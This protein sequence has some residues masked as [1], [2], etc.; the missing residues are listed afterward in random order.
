[1][2]VNLR[3]THLSMA[4]L[5]GIGV[6]PLIATAGAKGATY[7]PPTLNGANTVFVNTYNEAFKQAKIQQIRQMLKWDEKQQ[8]FARMQVLDRRALS[9]NPKVVLA[10]ELLEI[11]QH[12]LIGT[13]FNVPQNGVTAPIEGLL[14]SQYINSAL[15]TMKFE[16][17]MAAAANI[18]YQIL[19]SEERAFLDRYPVIDDIGGYE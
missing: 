19:V 12:K 2:F 16:D 18:V 3:V 8:Q 9:T 5:A 13:Y 10:V 4:G 15:R 7:T 6:G 1:M 14:V 17:G 11:Y